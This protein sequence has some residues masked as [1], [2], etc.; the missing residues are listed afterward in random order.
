VRLIWNNTKLW[1]F[2][3]SPLGFFLLLFQFQNAAS[4]SQLETEI[5][6]RGCL[7]GPNYQKSRSIWRLQISRSYCGKSVRNNT[8]ENSC[9]G[10]ESE[11]LRKWFNYHLVIICL[12]TAFG[13]Y[14]Q[15]VNQQ[16]ILH[17]WFLRN[18]CLYKIR[19]FTR[20]ILLHHEVNQTVIDS[21][22]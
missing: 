5:S 9:I 21:L 12:R 19:L 11:F 22:N 7:V 6:T 10:Y 17:F 8:H 1:N 4:K 14:F 16:L 18:L 13:V 15:D 2:L 20:V 3:Y